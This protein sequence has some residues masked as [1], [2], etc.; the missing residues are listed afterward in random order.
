MFFI[1]GD[2]YHE[3]FYFIDEN[4]ILLVEIQKLSTLF[5]FL[6]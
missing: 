5:F 4:Y 2:K 6:E 3:K 1:F